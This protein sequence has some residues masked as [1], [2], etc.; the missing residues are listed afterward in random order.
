MFAKVAEAIASSSHTTSV[1]HA[2]ALRTTTRPRHGRLLKGSSVRADAA[3]VCVQVCAH[4]RAARR[5]SR[6]ESVL[7]GAEPGPRPGS[8]VLVAPGALCR[9]RRNSSLRRNS[10]PSSAGMATPRA[11]G[12]SWRGAHPRRPRYRPDVA[13]AV[14]RAGAPAAARAPRSRRRHSGPA[15]AAPLGLT[16]QGHHELIFPT[17]PGVQAI[18]TFCAGV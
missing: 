8:A 13:G 1:H 18:R 16:G 4:A 7:K 2:A 10:P 17:N 9:L 14:F 6:R 11:L 3:K 12:S 5:C 15:M